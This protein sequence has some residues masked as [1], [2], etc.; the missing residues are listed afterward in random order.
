MPELRVD[1][2]A[3]HYADTGGSGPPVVLLH[4]FPLS[5]AMWSAQ[6]EA[7]AGRYRGIAPDLR[8]FG[9][10]DVPVEP[11]SYSM[12]GYADDVAALIDH[13]GCGPVT[14][15]GL[16]MGGYVAFAFLRRHRRLVRALVLADT[17]SAADSDEV[18][19]RR[20]A[21]QREVGQGRARAVI[22]AMANVLLSDRVYP[23]VRDR[24]V[25]LMD[26]PP[27]GIIGALEA[28][29]HRP[30]ATPGLG[31][32]DVPTLVVVGEE[33]PTA[34]VVTARATHQAIP[35]SELVV[36]PGAAHL[37]N[38]EAPAA[39]NDALLGFL[40]RVGPRPPAGA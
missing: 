16:S 5:S 12:D 26:Q 10:S 30:D 34:P 27:V 4:A 24:V 22:D 8:G 13:L 9:G 35:G 11:A 1:G 3:L 28:M 29:K 6:L 40:D 32:I 14:L 36:L 31:A 25:A 37:A 2:A 7:L 39:F 38:L 18:R 21:Q 23:V 19:R 17:R 15:V 20:A 33:D